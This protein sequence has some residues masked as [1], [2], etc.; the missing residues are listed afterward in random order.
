ML[1]PNPRRRPCRPDD[2]PS[3]PAFLGDTVTHTVGNTIVALYKLPRK[4]Y[5]RNNRAEPAETRVGAALWV[6][7]RRHPHRRA[8]VTLNSARPR[9]TRLWP[10]RAPCGV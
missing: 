2:S 10:P 8:A 1:S 7:G 9:S 4:R 3:D 5:R 6:R